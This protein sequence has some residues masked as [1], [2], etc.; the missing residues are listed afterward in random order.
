[1]L[2]QVH[3]RENAVLELWS[4]RKRR[5]LQCNRYLR[6]EAAV[7]K[8]LVHCYKYNLT[9]CFR[10]HLISNRR[11]A[12]ITNTSTIHVLVLRIF[13]TYEY[14]CYLRVYVHLMQ[15]RFAMTRFIMDSHKIIAEA[16]SALVSPNNFIET[17]DAILMV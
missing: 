6:I 1:M 13:V 7:T 10:N 17:Q 4:E 12:K 11:C 16:A 5:L 9:A 14:L 2:D 15:V 3:V 8:V